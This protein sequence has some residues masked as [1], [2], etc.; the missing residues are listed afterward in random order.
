MMSKNITIRIGVCRKRLRGIAVRTII[1]EIDPT[2]VMSWN[3]SIEV[4]LTNGQI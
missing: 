2:T 4:K 3:S 1:V